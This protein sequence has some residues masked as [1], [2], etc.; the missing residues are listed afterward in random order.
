M[1]PAAKTRRR[2]GL[3]ELVDQHSAVD[4]QPRL[5]G[6]RKR[7]TDAD[8]DNDQV[9]VDALAA[10]QRHGML[11]D[12]G[13]GPSEVEHDA[14]LLM[15]RADERSK[16]GAEHARHRDRLRTDDMHL[17][18]A[19]AQRRRGFEADEARADDHCFAGLFRLCDQSATV[20]ESAQIMNVIEV[21]ARNVELHRLGAGREQ[22]RAVTQTSAVGE[23][24]CALRVSI[25]ATRVFS[26][27]SIAFSSIEVGGPQ[28]RP[29]L[30]C[31]AGQI[32]LGQV[33]PVGGKRRIGAQHRD[34]PGIAFVAKRFG[35]HVSG[36]AAADDHDGLG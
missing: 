5:F 9:R 21:R 20:L 19:G 12:R 17:E 11:V 6:Q 36:R 4:G 16:L 34:R 26:R 35:G 33:R 23:F 10:V 25:R 2:A 24:D 3:E 22:K 13:C 18:A 29:F 28:Q 30:G 27:T 15:D 32:I 7:G 31:P 8:A 1:S 14:M